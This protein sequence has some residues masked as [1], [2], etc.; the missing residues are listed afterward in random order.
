MITYLMYNFWRFSLYKRIF[1]NLS[2]NEWQVNSEPAS[3]KEREPFFTKPYNP[4]IFQTVFSDNVVNIE[5]KIERK[6]VKSALLDK[7]FL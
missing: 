7:V 1:W 4:Q 2:S 3:W 6:Q 5:E